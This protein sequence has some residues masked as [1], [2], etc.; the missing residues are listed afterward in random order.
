MKAT[1]KRVFAFISAVIISVCAYAEENSFEVT[2]AADLVSSYVW[3]GAY[4]TGVS[5]QPSLTASYGGLSLSAWGSSDFTSLAKEIDFTLGYEIGGF[6]I[7]VSDYWWAGQGNDYLDYDLHFYEGCLSYSFGE[8]CP[9]SIAWYTMFMGE[10]DKNLENEQ[11]FSSYLE[12]GIDFNVKDVAMNFGIGITP[13]EGMYADKFNVTSVSLLASKEIKITEDFALPLFGQII[14]AP[15][16]K[17]AY[18]V[19]GIS[20]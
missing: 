9:I 19:A 7:A 5:I 16:N 17:D 4:Q 13:W 11:L 15:A 8:K 3:R 18:F 12:A 14:F 1:I 2:P 6:G 10:G 20:F